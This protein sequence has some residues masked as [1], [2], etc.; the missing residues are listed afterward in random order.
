MTDKKV[1]KLTMGGVNIPVTPIPEMNELNKDKIEELEEVR[2]LVEETAITLR[3]QTH[4]G[5]TTLMGW[6]KWDE[7][8]DINK[9]LWRD[10][11]RQILFN[12]NLA[13]IVKKGLPDISYHSAYPENEE[14]Y[15]QAM[16]KA[17]YL[18]VIPLLETKE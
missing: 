18:P 12:H 13:L 4:R 10:K 6:L 16:L 15:Q 1:E 11:A 8:S 9:E 7:L 17:G 3:E 14:Q 2:K 5:K